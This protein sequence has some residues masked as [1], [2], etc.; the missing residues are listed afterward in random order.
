MPLYMVTMMAAL[1][2]PSLAYRSSDSNDQCHVQVSPSGDD[3]PEEM[4]SSSKLCKDLEQSKRCRVRK[5]LPGMTIESVE[6]K[7]T[8][9]GNV[10]DPESCRSWCE[11]MF[12]LCEPGESRTSDNMG[13]PLK[14]C[15]EWE[16]DRQKCWFSTG[17]SRNTQSNEITTSD[18]ADDTFFSKPCAPWYMMDFWSE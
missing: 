4:S 18:D 9:I 10:A 2:A 14:A 11:M 7:N 13:C 1:Y 17:Y 12:N 5:E 3:A 16:G 8:A 15:C 6:H